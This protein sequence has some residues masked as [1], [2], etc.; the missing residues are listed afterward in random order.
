[1]CILTYQCLKYRPNKENLHYW[2]VPRA[3]LALLPP[4]S[5]LCRASGCLVHEHIFV[6]TSY[7]LQLSGFTP[8]CSQLLWRNSVEWKVNHHMF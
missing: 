3:L 4:L 5:L 2:C 7:T 6:T 1:M 8:C